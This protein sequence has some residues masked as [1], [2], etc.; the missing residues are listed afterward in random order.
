MRFAIE[1]DYSGAGLRGGGHILY[2]ALDRMARLDASSEFLCFGFFFKDYAAKLRQLR[3]P[4]HPNVKPCL[5]RWPQSLVISAEWKWGVPVIESYLSFKNVDAYHCFR[6]PPRFGN[7]LVN[8]YD[9]TPVIRPQWH[10]PGSLWLWRS[11]YEPGLKGAKRILT[12][13]EHTRD[14]LVRELKIAPERIK[15]AHLGVDLEL[16]RPVT[17]PSA[18]EPFRRKYALPERF[19]LMVGPLDAVCNFKAVVGALAGW[20]RSGGEPPIVVAVGPVDDYVRGLQRLAAESGVADRFLWTG[21]VHHEDLAF[22]YNLADALLHPSLLP[23]AELPPL[24]AMACGTP[25]I[26]SL[27]ENIGEAGLL[28]DAQSEADVGRAMRALWE[29]PQLR[30]RLGASGLERARGFGWERTAREMLAAYRET[31]G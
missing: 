9:I 30:R 1:F 21:Y 16:F 12:F 6:P 4:A 31:A 11:I 20:R 27:E 17:E 24:E 19:F 8:C 26:T 5:R 13:C 18:L 14:D 2:Q 15:I 23:G 7:T 25:V 29:A 22:I 28:I 3:A 10:N